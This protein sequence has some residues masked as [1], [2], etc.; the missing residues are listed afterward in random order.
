MIYNNIANITTIYWMKKCF[1]NYFE[2]IT[3][4]VLDSTLE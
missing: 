3:L 2:N 4:E 1:T